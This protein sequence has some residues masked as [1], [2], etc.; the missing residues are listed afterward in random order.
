MNDKEYQVFLETKLRNLKRKYSRVKE[1]PD[2][3]DTALELH[4]EIET[5]ED[6]LAMT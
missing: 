3:T 1:H 2:L 4:R 5:I 6:Y